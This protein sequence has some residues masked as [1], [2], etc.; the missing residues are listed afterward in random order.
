MIFEIFSVLLTWF[1]LKYSKPSVAAIKSSQIFV[2]VLT[3]K[4][5]R[6][7]SNSNHDDMA[8]A[9]PLPMSCRFTEVNIIIFSCTNN[10]N[11]CFFFLYS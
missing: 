9:L 10:I 5:Q 11:S 1:V 4:K 7:S 2:C 6:R 8:N 3:P